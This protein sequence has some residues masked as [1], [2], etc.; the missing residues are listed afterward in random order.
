M[1]ERIHQLAPSLRGTPHLLY[2]GAWFATLRRWTGQQHLSLAL[3]AS[4]RSAPSL[5][6]VVGCLI[7][8]MVVS[9][10]SSPEQTFDR[11]VADLRDQVLVDW[12]H[13]DVPQEILVEALQPQ[14]TASG[15]YPLSNVM[16]A[17]QEPQPAPRTWGDATLL[18]MHAAYGGFSAFDATL[19][20]EAPEDDAPLRLVFLYRPDTISDGDATLLLDSYRDVVEAIACDPGVCL[21]KLPPASAAQQNQLVHWNATHREGEPR[22]LVD[23]LEQA[24]GQDGQREALR[25]RGESFSLGRL[26]ELADLLARGLAAAGVAHGDRVLVA[27]GRSPETV[28]VM[29]AI[30]KCGA[31]FVPLDLSHPA[32]RLNRIVA[33]AQ[34]RLAVLAD[35]TVHCRAA[36]SV[37]LECRQATIEQLLREGRQPKVATTKANG[38][39]AVR[40]PAD[41]AYLMYTSGS[42]GEPKGVQVPHRALWNLLRS[43][44]REPGIAAGESILAHT[45]LSFDISLLEVWLP[46]VHGG[47]MILADDA[48][49]LDAHL[50]RSLIETEKPDIVQATPSVF[51]WLM[52]AGWRP[53]GQRL[54]CGG[55]ALASD[56]AGELLASSVEL[57]NVYGPTETTV[58][59]TIQRLDDPRMAYSIGRPIDNTQAV[60]VDANR[61]SLGPGPVGEL[62]LGGLGLALDYWNDEALTE[63]RF[64]MLEALGDPQRFYRTG[65]LARWTSDGR[66]MFVGRRDQQVKVRGHRIELGEVE[67]ALREHPAVIDACAT[68]QRHTLGD[69]LAAYFVL[70][71]DVHD[72]PTAEE[73]HAFVQQRL[74]DYMTPSSFTSLEELP[75]SAAGKLDRSRLPAP[76]QAAD[77][78]T[79]AP[80][81]SPLEVKI[82][83]IW[84]EVL[85]RPVQNVHES[86][87]VLGGHSLLA[88]Q[89]FARLQDELGGQRPPIADFYQHPTV[90]GMA[91][92][93]LNHQFRQQGEEAERLLRELE[94]LSDEEARELLDLP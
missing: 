1:A 89:V 60:V 77:E 20:V 2:L 35:A 25:W 91:E 85:Q 39:A 17:Y 49:G 3:P 29:W 63:Q 15:V 87:F 42:T 70:K 81:Q 59:L 5:A 44:A 67:T 66:L 32:S 21:A 76:R 41:A 53:D 7:N 40:D 11:F 4:Q 86:F 72:P 80:P 8:T 46:L 36:D 9:A 93:I 54:W 27:S 82:A 12:E 62:C 6:N 18:D 47:C 84:S 64:V 14:R 31:A 88:M 92:A 16:F 75:R 68:V 50:L 22:H 94:S 38:F 52:L 55:E 83:S 58:W 23:V 74:P 69:S 34:A 78:Q 61:Q 65:D 71:A 13:A 56:L 90:A 28:A 10:E 79:V 26:R 24:V 43:F 19:I 37:L 48:A 57:W 73:L 51:R 45:T 33:S 30:W